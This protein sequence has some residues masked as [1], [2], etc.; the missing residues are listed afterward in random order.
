MHV[1]LKPETCSN[2]NVPDEH[3]VFSVQYYN[4]K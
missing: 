2:M 1:L 3:N 4:L